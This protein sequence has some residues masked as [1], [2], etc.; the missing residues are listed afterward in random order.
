LKDSVS[1]ETYAG[2]GAYGPTY[3]AAVT[4]PCNVEATRRLVR[5]A[6]GDEVVSESTLFVH[7]DDVASFVPESLLTFETR[8][9]RVLAVSPRTFRGAT[10]HAEVS[11]A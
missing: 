2:D 3:A 9:S 8:T 6:A 5:N 7:P 1:V 4:V 10:S 11:C